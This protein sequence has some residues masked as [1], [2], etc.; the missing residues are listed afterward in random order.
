M[1]NWLYLIAFFFLVQAMVAQ[2]QLAR[3]LN[4]YVV[5]SEQMLQT[6]DDQ[7][8]VNNSIT[9]K[10]I[11]R[12]NPNSLG[13]RDDIFAIFNDGNS[14]HLERG[15]LDPWNYEF[16]IDALDNAD[17]AN[18][19]FNSEENQ[20]AYLYFT[21]VYDDDDDPAELEST[22]AISGPSENVNLL[23]RSSLSYP[24]RANQTVVPDKDI[25]LVLYVDARSERFDESLPDYFV[26]RYDKYTD[27]EYVTSDGFV[28]IEGRNAAIGNNSLFEPSPIFGNEPS[29]IFPENI[30]TV[31]P[32]PGESGFEFNIV[33]PDYQ[34]PLFVNLRPRPIMREIIAQG[35]PSE[36]PSVVRPTASIFE[37]SAGNNTVFY[38]ETNGNTHDPNRLL[39][40]GVCEECPSVFYEGQ[41]F[42]SSETPASG[43]G[44]EFELPS[45][46]K[47]ESIK[48]T[49]EVTVADI[50][51]AIHED[52]IKIS[53]QVVSV[54]L[55]DDKSIKLNNDGRDT[56][57]VKFNFCVNTNREGAIATGTPLEIYMTSKSY[58]YFFKHSSSPQK[59]LL[60]NL[61][62]ECK[63]ISWG[64][65]GIFIS[66]QLIEPCKGTQE[67]CEMCR[68][69]TP[70]P[71]WTVLLSIV[72]LLVL[73]P[74]LWRIIVPKR[75]QIG[76]N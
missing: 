69:E 60:S 46:L 72:I 22:K 54:S 50:P 43:L 6:P 63:K 64:E 9:I 49:L 13:A 15:T 30:C 31:S 53:G 58:V 68:C 33:D 7:N 44:F 10:N 35:T 21:N 38:G 37:V 34:G 55:P 27:A 16:D 14:F 62:N 17:I 48:K 24:I 32:L 59:Y 2:A 56:A 61:A 75:P 19:A 36:D 65:T 18:I 74:I 73:I 66:Q 4:W 40:K 12:L 51:V 23:S 39:V 3:D 57:F 45:S 42:N 25:T 29:F 52:S 8:D 76:S 1:K 20:I 5:D 67:D 11:R 26:L 71:P 28:T 47:A 41:F 70:P